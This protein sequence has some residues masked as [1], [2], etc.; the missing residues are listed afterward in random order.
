MPGNHE[1]ESPGALPYFE[2]FGELASG[3]TGQGYYSFEVGDWHVVALNS[4]V[5]V[6][7]D[8]SRR[9]PGSVTIW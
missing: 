8:I 9:P 4:N 3:P 1:Y 6:G 7:V 5:P 2:Y